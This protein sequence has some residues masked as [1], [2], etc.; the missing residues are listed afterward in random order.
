LKQNLRT[1]VWED[2]WSVEPRHVHKGVE[3]WRWRYTLTAVRRDS[4]ALSI[5]RPLR[6]SIVSDGDTITV[7]YQGAALSEWY[8]STSAGIEQ[9]FTINERPLADRSTGPLKLRGT[10]TTDLV[11]TKRSKEELLFAE[12]DNPEEVALRYADLKVTD[13]RGRDLPSRFAYPQAA[14]RRRIVDIEIDD[15]DAVYPVIVDPVA[16]SPS[17]A[18]SGGGSTMQFGYSI[19]SAG[20][21]NKDGYGDIIIGAPLYDNGSTNEGAVFVFHGS[22]TG[23]STTPNWKIESDNPSYYYGAAVTG[24]MDLNKDTFADIAFSALGAYNCGGSTLGRVM[25][26]HGSSSGLGAT[27]N[28]TLSPGTSTYYCFGE[29]LAPGGDQ[30]GDTYDDL[31]IGAPTGNG[32]CGRAFVCKGSSTGLAAATS[33]T[34]PAFVQT[35]TNQGCGGSFGKS[36]CSGNFNGDAYAD[37]AIADS[38]W[39]SSAINNDRGRVYFRAGASSLAGATLTT[40]AITGST[41]LYGMGYAL[42][43]PGDLNR[44]GYDDV[45]IADT[46]NSNLYVYTGRSSSVVPT[47]SQTIP[48]S[49]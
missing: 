31:L 14:G 33:A 38:E 11:L 25:A 43:C 36:L 2:G 32:S 7:P 45:V 28:S 1:Y 42:A 17:W 41:N 15:S 24:G 37:F 26:F 23:L 46:G 8:R 4:T 35:A 12:R 39:D 19:S 6:D 29:K 27:A 13:A 10:I 16:S 49:I 30:N 22:S 5:K 34:C 40:N 48:L 3:K 18:L 21:I 20:D 47:L 9:G 44:D